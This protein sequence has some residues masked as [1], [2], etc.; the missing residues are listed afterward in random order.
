M[1]C[2]RCNK[3][4]KTNLTEGEEIKY[5]ASSTGLWVH[6]Y[7]LNNLPKE[8]GG[9]VEMCS[10]DDRPHTDRYPPISCIECKGSVM[11]K[12]NFLEYSDIIFDYCPSCGSFWLDKDELSRMHNYIKK[13][14]DGVHKIGNKTSFDLLVRLSKISYLIFH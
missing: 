9:D 2:P 10:I 3:K 13:V 5:Y 14:E 4:I 8:S 1:K 12:I 6:K 7:Q 11:K